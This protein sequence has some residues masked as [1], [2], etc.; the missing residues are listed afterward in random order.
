MIFPVWVKRK[1]A[2]RVGSTPFLLRTNNVVPSSASRWASCKA[3]PQPYESCPHI[4]RLEA[5][6]IVNIHGRPPLNAQ[7]YTGLMIRVKALRH[8][9][10]KHICIEPFKGFCDTR[11]WQRKIHPYGIWTVKWA[12]V[13]PD[14][15][16]ADTG[17]KQLV[18]C[19]LMSFAPLLAV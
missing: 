9:C 2:L 19:L 8:L 3:A 12:S 15:A 5:F 14:H 6:Q 1:S 11:V 4:N 16:N 7:A 10:V 17:Q 13:L 18:Q